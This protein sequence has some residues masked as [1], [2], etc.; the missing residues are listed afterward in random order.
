MPKKGPNKEQ[1]HVSIV[2]DVDKIKTGFLFLQNEERLIDLMNDDRPFL[3]FE[4][5]DGTFSILRKTAI[6]EITILHEGMR[7]KLARK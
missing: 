2:F 3:P 1:C 4:Y 7:S 5:D 6:L